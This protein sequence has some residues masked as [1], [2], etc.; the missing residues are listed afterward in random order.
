VTP[1]HDPV[2]SEITVADIGEVVALHQ[3]LG[4]GRDEDPER[5]RARWRWIWNENPAG[6]ADQ[7]SPVLG[8]CLRVDGRIV[9]AFCNIARLYRFRGRDLRIA[10]AAGWAVEKGFRAHTPLLAAE[11]FG[12][13][14]ADLLLVST[15]SVPTGRIFTRFGGSPIPV[16]EVGSVSYWV[17]DARGFVAAAF[18][19]KGWP[20]IAP[21][22][23]A[24]LGPAVSAIAAL[25]GR[26]PVGPSSLELRSEVVPW[27]AIDAEL[28]GLWRRTRDARPALLAHRASRDLRWYFGARVQEGQ[29]T[30]IACRRNGTL[31]GY[32]VLRTDDVV[33]H[34]LSRAHVADLLVEADQPEAIDSLLAA[35][36]DAAAASG[37]QVLE[38]RGYS[39]E[40]R[41][42]A[43]RFRPLTRA[44]A[45]FPFYYKALRPDLEASLS[46]PRSWYPTPFD[47]DA[48][49]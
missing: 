14:H 35:C 23:A 28:D 32:A 5:L 13:P 30:P 9:G 36:Y 37:R 40:V 21:F 33:A 29:V 12:Q 43:A 27:G 44:L 4:L 15:A 3:R 19:K 10:V 25:P 46:D 7:P 17:L 49:L 6:R 26:R 2:V 22:A 38:I 45:S 18:R 48:A 20:R 1:T 11:Y 34:G 39:E 41:S 47:G 31:V 42:R 16:T 8:W 24:L